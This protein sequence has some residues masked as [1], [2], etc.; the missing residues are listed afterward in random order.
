MTPGTPP[1]TVSSEPITEAEISSPKSKSEEEDSVSSA[2]YAFLEKEVTFLRKA[3]VEKDQALKDKEDAI[4][5]LLFF[6]SRGG[7]TEMFT[8]FLFHLIPN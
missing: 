7:N 4:E 1:K 6:S 3:G 5:V 8:P 2:L